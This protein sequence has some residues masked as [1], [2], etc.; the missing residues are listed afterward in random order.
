[1]SLE[2]KIT[3]IHNEK[4]QELVQMNMD[5]FK[6]IESYIEDQGLLEAMLENDLSDTLNKEDALEFYS[7]LKKES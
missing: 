5:V 6:A 7:K 2:E 3:I 4:G 1:M